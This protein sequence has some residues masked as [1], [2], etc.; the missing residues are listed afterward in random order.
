MMNLPLLTTYTPPPRLSL[1]PTAPDTAVFVNICA[2]PDMVNKP[3]ATPTPPP[4]AALLPA[5]V[6]PVMVNS[7]FVPET[8]T[9]PPRSPLFAKVAGFVM[10]SFPEIVPPVMTNLPPFPTYTPPPPFLLSK[11]TSAVLSKISP[12][13]SVKLPFT[14]TPPPLSVLRP[15]VILPPVRESFTVRLAPALTVMTLPLAIPT[16]SFL[17]IE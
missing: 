14:M 1:S 15:P 6:P 2:V 16:V 5:I 8:K 3:S 12:L 13:C 9:P 11:P 7:L 17:S 4:N 10:T